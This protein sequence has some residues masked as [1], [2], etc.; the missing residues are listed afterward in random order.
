[1]M[2]YAAVAATALLR[3]R[4]LL[5]GALV[6]TL[7]LGIAFTYSRGA[8]GAALAG[9]GA[10]ALVESRQALSRRLAPVAVAAFVFGSFAAAQE[11][12]RVRLSEAGERDFYAARYEAPRE[13]RMAPREIRHLPVKVTNDGSRSWRRIERFNLSYHLRSATGGDLVGGARTRLT[14]DVAPGESIDLLAELRAPGRPGR[15]EVLWDLVHEDTTWFSGQGVA[16][17]ATSLLVGAEPAGT[18]Q[19]VPGPGETRESVTDAAL[20]AGLNGELAWRPTRS[21]L[22]AIAA[23]MWASNPFL[24]VGPDNYRRTYGRWV[25]RDVFDSRVYANNL[26]LE[27]AAT[28]GTPGLAA[29]LAAVALALRRSVSRAREDAVSAAAFGVLAVLAVHGLVDFTLAFTGHYLVAGFALGASIAAD[30]AEPAPS[31]SAGVTGSADS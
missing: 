30:A 3:E 19:T 29:F 14:R 28:V 20:V 21:E 22:W 5:R 12:A 7:S 4:A 31:E 6:G 17:G 8:A 10:L 16:P 26:C 27:L 23:R 1:M 11:V 15:Y 25:G 9:L 13:T 2:A 18:D 24:G